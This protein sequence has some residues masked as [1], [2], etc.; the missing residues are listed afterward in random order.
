MGQFVTVGGFDTAVAWMDLVVGSVA[1]PV[2]VVGQVA[3]V[4]GQVVAGRKNQRQVVRPPRS[5]LR[6]SP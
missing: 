3:P 1:D 4:V 2:A 5:L 6:P